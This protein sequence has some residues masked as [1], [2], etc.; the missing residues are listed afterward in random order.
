MLSTLDQGKTCACC[1]PIFTPVQWLLLAVRRVA[2]PGLNVPLALDNGE[3]ESTATRSNV[4]LTTKPPPNYK[5]APSWHHLS[6]PMQPPG[7]WRAGPSE[8]LILPENTRPL[9]CG[10]SLLGRCLG[11]GPICQVPLQQSLHS[12]SSGANFATGG[13]SAADFRALRTLERAKS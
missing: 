7:S 4:T 2:A 9:R 13:P 12:G 3:A 10:G 1:F 6:P 5:S 11:P 8:F